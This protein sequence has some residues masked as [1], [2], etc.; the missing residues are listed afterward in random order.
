VAAELAA[1]RGRESART[2]E[3]D[4]A[5]AELDDERGRTAR[6]V[7]DLRA[8]AD[9]ATKLAAQHLPPDV[10]RERFRDL[11]DGDG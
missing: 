5:L 2:D 1:A 4:R 7:A 11:L 8:R 10:L 6:Q 9:R 3:R